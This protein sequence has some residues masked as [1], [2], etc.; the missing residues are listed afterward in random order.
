MAIKSGRM[1]INMGGAC[2]TGAVYEKR[3][4]SLTWKE[5]ITWRPRPRYSTLDKIKFS[6]VMCLSMWSNGGHL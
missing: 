4:I 6:G 2:N 1:Q 5:V 3:N